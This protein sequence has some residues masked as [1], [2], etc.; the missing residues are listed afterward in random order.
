MNTKT[1]TL[2]VVSFVLSIAPIGVFL[3][4]NHEVYFSTNATSIGVGVFLGVFF[5]LMALKDKLGHLLKDNA[6]LKVSTFF[7]FFFWMLQ[8]ISA[9]L[10]ILSALSVFGSILAFVPNMLANKEIKKT[11]RETVATANATAMTTAFESA[12]ITISSRSE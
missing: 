4:I 12:G 6:Q 9:D 5:L 11:N 7:L 1:I 8:Q 2:K 10:L 3:G